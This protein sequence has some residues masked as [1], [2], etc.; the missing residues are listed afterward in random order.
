MAAL[1]E[2]LMLFFTRPRLTAHEVLEEQIENTRQGAL[3]KELKALQGLVSD[4]V[5][6]LV[7]DGDLCDF[8]RLLHEGW[9]LKRQFSTQVADREIDEWYARARRAGAVG[10]KLVGAGGG[11]FLL[12]LAEPSKQQVVRA[13]LR[14]LHEVPIAFEQQGTVL[15]FRDF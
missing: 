13:A 6:L 11:G 10:G 1:E 14:D 2:H 9:M 4:G 8:G 7:G 12:L 3:V 5:D 15:V